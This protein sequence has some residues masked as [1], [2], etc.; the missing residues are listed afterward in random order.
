[1]TFSSSFNTSQF[2]T[3]ETLHPVPPVCTPSHPDSPSSFRSQ[4]KCHLLR[5]D[6]LSPKPNTYPQY[7]HQSLE[8]HI[9]FLDFHQ[10]SH[11]NTFHKSRDA[12]RTGPGTYRF[13][14]ITCWMNECVLNWVGATSA[15]EGFICYVYWGIA[16]SWILRPQAGKNWSGTSLAGY[17]GTRPQEAAE[18]GLL[19]REFQE[20]SQD[21]SLT[22]AT[23]I[24]TQGL[25]H[26]PPDS[27]SQEKQLNS[28]SSP[29][30]SLRSQTGGKITFVIT[31]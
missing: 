6:P 17:P 13:S 4:L 1:M 9:Y 12:L 5:T 29:D 10:S 3:S 24:E 30:H 7:S 8:I 14:I 26:T 27:A 31:A 11:W 21:Q 20:Q 15:K 18:K 25:T 2:P 22:A 19:Q 23:H 28:S 16:G